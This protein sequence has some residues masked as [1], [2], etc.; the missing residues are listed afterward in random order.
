MIQL[1]EANETLSWRDLWITDIKI[2][3]FW[4]FIYTDESKKSKVWI[5]EKWRKF[6]K[7]LI[8]VPLVAYVFNNQL[9]P[10]PEWEK[11]EYVSIHDLVDDYITRDTML[12]EA[13]PLV[14]N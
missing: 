1:N 2:L 12:Q 11:E 7:W 13:I 14:N 10:T 4:W 5:T 9:Q 3:K 6:L 8:R